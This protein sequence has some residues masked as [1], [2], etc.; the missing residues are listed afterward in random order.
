VEIDSVGVLAVELR[1]MM[2]LGDLVGFWEA[3][4][5]EYVP[6]WRVGEE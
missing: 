2:S 1:F 6:E 4:G 3:G 5:T